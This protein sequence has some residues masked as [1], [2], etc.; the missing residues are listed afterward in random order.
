MLFTV[1]IL[2]PN[3]TRTTGDRNVKQ[4]GPLGFR[5]PTRRARFASKS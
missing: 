1:S 3:L 2:R 4:P 5:Q